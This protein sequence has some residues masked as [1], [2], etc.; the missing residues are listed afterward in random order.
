MNLN[1]VN[2]D[3]LVKIAEKIEKENME[4]VIFTKKWEILYYFWKLINNKLSIEEFYMF[5]DV[6]FKEKKL[7]KYKIKNWKDAL[8]YL[9]YN[10]K[11]NKIYVLDNL[12]EE[13]IDIENVYF[14]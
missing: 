4:P 6:F 2:N 7:Y 11:K 3:E 1:N 8:E 13:K 14:V 9:K 10:Y 5:N 12:F